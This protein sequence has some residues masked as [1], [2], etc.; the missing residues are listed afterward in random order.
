ML[1]MKGVCVHVKK[2]MSTSIILHDLFQE[3][4]QKLNCHF[5]ISENM[6]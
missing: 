3:G 2:A 1:S 4:K 6:L 5:M